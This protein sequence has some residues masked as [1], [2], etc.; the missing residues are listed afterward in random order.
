MT[1][2]LQAIE[3][4]RQR[5]LAYVTEVT[6]LPTEQVAVDIL[7]FEVSEEFLS[8]A[9]ML[10]WEY[11]EAGPDEAEAEPDKV[12]WYSST[13]LGHPGGSVTVCVN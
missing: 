6:G 12:S 9:R 8:D 13:P 5:I 7:L 10:E 1:S 3:K 4:I 2:T 11:N